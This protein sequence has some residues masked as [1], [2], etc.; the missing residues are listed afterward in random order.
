LP[1]ARLIAT[2][3]VMKDSE[4]PLNAQI[5]DIARSLVARLP[6]LNCFLCAVESCTGGLIAD[7]ITEVP[8]SSDMFWGSIV[9]YENSAKEGLLDVPG[10]VLLRRGAVS[11]EVAQMLAESGLRNMKNAWAAARSTGRSVP[12]RFACIATTGIAGPGG[13][14]AQKQ[15]GLCY[16]ALAVDNESATVREVHAPEGLG[17]TGNKQ[18][19]ARAALELVAQALLK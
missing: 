3:V 2:R 12:Q 6:G 7:R 14:T 17:R 13:G 18:Y 8:G 11:P 19:F 9:A 10:H 5:N 15:V 4:N 1:I 16:I